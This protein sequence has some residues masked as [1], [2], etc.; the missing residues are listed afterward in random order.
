SS[1]SPEASLGEAAELYGLEPEK[2]FT[3]SQQGA[4]IVIAPGI[5][6]YA[7]ARGWYQDDATLAETVRALT[8]QHQKRDGEATSPQV[9]DVIPFPVA[10]LVEDEPEVDIPEVSERARRILMRAAEVYAADDSEVRSEE[11]T[12]ELQSRENLVCR[13]LLEKK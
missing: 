4:A 8:S 10:E 1:V 6:T 7:T 11:H 5:D 3:R 12:S 9:A 13:L 2:E